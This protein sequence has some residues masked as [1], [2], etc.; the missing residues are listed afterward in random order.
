VDECTIHFK[1]TLP[2]LQPCP[3]VHLHTCLQF[4]PHLSGLSARSK[5]LTAFSSSSLQYINPGCSLALCQIFVS[6]TLHYLPACLPACPQT[7][8]S[9]ALCTSLTHVYMSGRSCHPP[10]ALCPLPQPAV[11]FT[12]IPPPSPFD[13]AIYFLPFTCLSACVWVYLTATD[14]LLILSYTGS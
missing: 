5:Y 12:P 4:A 3:S 13:P 14:I 11:I 9:P 6:V 10:S 8:A 7:C 1:R 2:Q